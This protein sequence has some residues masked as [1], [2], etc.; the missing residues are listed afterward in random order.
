MG[1]RGRGWVEEASGGTRAKPD[2]QVGGVG[3]GR[4]CRGITRGG[5]A[6]REGRTRGDGGGDRSG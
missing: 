6:P 5:W 4:G 1:A 3:R 2:W